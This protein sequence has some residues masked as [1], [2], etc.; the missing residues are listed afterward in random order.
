MKRMMKTTVT[1]TRHWERKSNGMNERA[2]ESRENLQLSQIYWKHNKK[3]Y[4]K[5]HKRNVFRVRINYILM[6]KS[7]FIY[8]NE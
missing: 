3:F 1:N 7:I 2:H 6:S 5:Y 4:I 8:I